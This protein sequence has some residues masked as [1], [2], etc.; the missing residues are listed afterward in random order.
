VNPDEIH[1]GETA[2]NT[3][4][5]YRMAYIPREIIQELLHAVYGVE[6][7][8]AYFKHIVTCDTALSQRLLYTFRL[9]EENF[10]DLLHAQLCFFQAITDLF[11]RYAQP[12]YTPRLFKSHPAMIRKAREFI[13]AMA[14]ANISLEDIADMAGMSRFHFLRLFKATTGFSPYAYLIQRRVEIAKMLIESGS[15]LAQAALEAGFSDQSHMT[16]RFKATYGVTPGQY[17]QALEK[18]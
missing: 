5:Q 10:S 3:G 14:P 4:Y 2:T 7:A 6:D 13:H 15:S 1:T 8:L 11:C 16:R 17:R 12:Q 18:K 9:L